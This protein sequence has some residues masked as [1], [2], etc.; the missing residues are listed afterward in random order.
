MPRGGALKLDIEAVTAAVAGVLLIAVGVL[1][2]KSRL[3][4][5]DRRR[6]VETIETLRSQVEALRGDLKDASL[7]DTLTG[8]RNRRFFSAMIEGDLERVRRAFSAKSNRRR[9]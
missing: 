5:A 2:L 4:S 3:E 6:F 8:L 9:N 7:T 1:L